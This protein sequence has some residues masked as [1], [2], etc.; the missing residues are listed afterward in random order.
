MNKTQFKVKVEHG[1]DADDASSPLTSDADLVITTRKRKPPSDD[2][3][4]RPR[5]PESQKKVKTR[6]LIR[7]PVDLI[8]SAS[9]GPSRPSDGPGKDSSLE[10]DVHYDMGSVIKRLTQD[11]KD[12]M[13]L[14]KMLR[15]EISQL[16]KTIETHAADQKKQARL[17]NVNQKCQADRDRK[18]EVL[19]HEKHEMD[20]QNVSL[21]E[22]LRTTSDH[23][24][25]VS[26]RNSSLQTEVE[27][28]KKEIFSNQ[29]KDRVSDEYLC[30][31][32]DRVGKKISDWVDS[33]VSV[34]Q[35]RFANDYVDPRNIRRSEY[36]TAVHGSPAAVEFIMHELIFST[37]HENMLADGLFL[38]GMDPGPS[39]IVGTVMHCLIAR[40]TGK[41]ECTEKEITKSC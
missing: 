6:S 41:G 29:P 39:G 2:E 1:S 40:A 32:F 27:A 18:F 20:V 10:V 9:P 36:S 38:F 12:E 7:Q 8:M 3:E 15:K 34:L 23:L 37:I 11:Y 13:F 22:K 14:V 5:K 25:R 28:L 19:R 24:G 21:V 4:Y 31:Q 16:K 30:S 17:E 33:T 35:D 26:R